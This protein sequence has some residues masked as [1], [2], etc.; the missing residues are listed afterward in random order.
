M[1]GSTVRRAKVGAAA[2]LLLTACFPAQAR[3]PFRTPSGG[4]GGD[5]KLHRVRLEVSCDTCDVSWAVAFRNGRSTERGLWRHSEVVSAGSDAPEVARLSA[6]AVRDA[7]AVSYVR[8]FVDERLAAQATFD[9]TASPSARSGGMQTLTVQ[10]DVPALSSPI[11]VGGV[12]GRRR[13]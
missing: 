7:G 1:D 5:Y 4:G 3:D 13:R 12:G 10:T 6:T 9:P 11:V 8:I 2:T